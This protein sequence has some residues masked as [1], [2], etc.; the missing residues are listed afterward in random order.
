MRKLLK[1]TSEGL[2]L[3]IKISGIKKKPIKRM[4]VNK[5]VYINNLFFLITSLFFHEEYKI[6][7]PKI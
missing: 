3:M 5:K 1:K 6:R 7:R 4:V 2:T